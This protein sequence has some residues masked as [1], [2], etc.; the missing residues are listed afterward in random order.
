MQQPLAIFDVGARYDFP[1]ELGSVH[2]M[3]NPFASQKNSV[4][5]GIVC[6]TPY[7]MKEQLPLIIPRHLV[8][9]LFTLLYEPS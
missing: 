2:W 4:S 5:E 8:L 1:H 3:P 9:L 7:G 6:M